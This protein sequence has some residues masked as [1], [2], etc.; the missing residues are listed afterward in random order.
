MKQLGLLI[1][2]L[3]ISGQVFAASFTTISDASSASL[4][5]LIK[6][7]KEIVKNK[8]SL[9]QATTLGIY[10]YVKKNES[11]SDVNM[12]KQMSYKKGGANSDDNYEEL[13][14]SSVAQIVDFSYKAINPQDDG[15]EKVFKTTKDSLT[16]ALKEVKKNHDL[17]IFGNGHADE[18]GS[19][20]IIFVLDTKTKE[21]VMLKIGFIGT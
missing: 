5:A 2:S 15:S 21:I 19:W 16:E 9:G 18:D 20:Q 8:K 4:K 14:K 3:T 6:S 7:G 12:L 1:I 10:S 13:S 17:K 11:D